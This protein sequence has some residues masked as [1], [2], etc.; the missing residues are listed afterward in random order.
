MS[1]RHNLGNRGPSFDH[2]PAPAGGTT[3]M[4]S[5]GR[6]GD[7]LQRVVI[8][9]TTTAAGDVSIKDGSATAIKIF[10]TGTLEDLKPLVVDLELES[11]VG[12]WQIVCGANVAALGVGYF[13]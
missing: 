7:H 1:T 4:S 9:P 6:A 10:N 5:T 8:I 3:A 13:S 11:K 12:G 2:T